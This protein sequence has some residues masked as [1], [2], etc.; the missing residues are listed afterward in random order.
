M[1]PLNNLNQAN[2]LLMVEG[3]QTVT[4]RH[5]V[6]QHRTALRVVQRRRVH[7]HRRRTPIEQPHAVRLAAQRHA[8]ADLRARLQHRIGRGRSPLC[9][10][11]GQ[12]EAVG[13]RLLGEHVDG[14]PG[15]RIQLADA[16]RQLPVGELAPAVDGSERICVCE[17]QSRD[18][19]RLIKS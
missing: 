16:L 4:G 3:A 13:A 2:S 14:G 5:P 18:E 11:R 6:H 15:D 9:G 1:V 7:K 17:N 12:T 10:Q 8:Q 19:S